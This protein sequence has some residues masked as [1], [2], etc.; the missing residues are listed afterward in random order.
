M[1]GSGLDIRRQGHKRNNAERGVVVVEGRM[2]NQMQGQKK[3]TQMNSTNLHPF[4]TLPLPEPVTHSAL[5]IMNAKHN[6]ILFGRFQ[7]S[8]Q[9]APH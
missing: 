2:K 7:R 6:Q 1:Q 4:S 8:A 9:T 3:H 5:P